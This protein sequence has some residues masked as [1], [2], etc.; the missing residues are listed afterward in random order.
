M[1]STAVARPREQTKVVGLIGVG[2]F[3]S[4]FT[5][6]ILPPLFPFMKSEFGI[7]YVALGGLASAFNVATGASQV[8]LGFAVDRFGGRP[9][10]LCGLAVLGAAFVLIS[11]ADSY[12]QIVALLVLGGLA[13]GVFHPADYSILSAR[14]SEG[15]LG[16]AMSLHSFSGYVG[17]AVAPLTMLALYGLAGWR[18]AVAITGLAGVALALAMLAFG[19][20]LDDQIARRTDKSPSKSPSSRGRDLMRSLPMIMMFLFFVC[21]SAVSS[22]FSS[23]AVVAIDSLYSVGETVAGYGLTGFLVAMAI[24]VLIG[25]VLADATKRHNLVA[26][27]ATLVAG[28]LFVVVSSAAL[29]A[30]FALAAIALGGLGYGISSPSRDLIVRASAPPGSIG[31][32]FGFTSTGIGV[33]GAIGPLLCGLLMDADRPDLAFLL[34]AVLSIA[35]V[36]AVWATR[37]RT[38]EATARP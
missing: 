35:A 21:M 11:M 25:G 27:L 22:G 16:R 26:G 5:A 33:G 20:S 19:G 1:S 34:I 4:H 31:V 13:N 3:F 2:H 10:L 28:L 30:Y 32:A 8:P 17:F 7:S 18:T 36:G 9:L 29:S 6:L 37:P 14:I 38:A 12:W 24:G 15:Y 23:L